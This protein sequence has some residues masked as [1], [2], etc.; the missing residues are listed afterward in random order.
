MRANQF[1]SGTKRTLD[2]FLLKIKLPQVGGYSRIMDTSVQARN[3]EMAR[4]I[5]RAQYGDRTVIVGNPK[6]INTK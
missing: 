2:T 4:R 1:I 5:V 6:K 3:H